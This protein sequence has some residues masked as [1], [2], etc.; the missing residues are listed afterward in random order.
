MI[1]NEIFSSIE[2]EGKRAG[3]LATFVRFAGC[4]LNCSYCDTKYAQ[5]CNAGKEMSSKEIFNVIEEIGNTNITFTGG[6]P[7]LQHGLVDL[8]K[9]LSYFS[10]NINVETNGSE[11]ISEFLPIDDCFLT[12]DY[13][14]PSSGCENKMYLDNFSSLR[15][16]DVIKCVVQKPDL[17]K[18][19]YVLSLR[20]P[21]R[22]PFFYISPVYG[23]IDLEDIVD[24]MKSLHENGFDMT[25]VKMQVQ[26]HKI[27][28]GADIRGV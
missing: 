8:V 28:W 24:K 2:G 1:V 27:I 9:T 10:C 5:D 19:D 12:I 6:E 3:E 4:N 25:K 23:K 14:M 18:L 17:D 13:K 22:L 11:D 21:I 16:Q 7:L 20:N 26:L 15:M